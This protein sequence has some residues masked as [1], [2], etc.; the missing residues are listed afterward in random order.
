MRLL[1]RTVVPGGG[2]GSGGGLK[3]PNHFLETVSL[4]DFFDFFVRRD[5]VSLLPW[6]IFEGEAESSLLTI[7][8]LSSS[9]ESF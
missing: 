9:V 6:N 1:E 8:S 7:D 2:S 4:P 5:V 3:A